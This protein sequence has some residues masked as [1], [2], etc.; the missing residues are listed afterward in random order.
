MIPKTRN[1]DLKVLMKLF[2][3][4]QIL[5]THINYILN[6]LQILQFMY[7]AEIFMNLLLGFFQSEL[8]EMN[9]LHKVLVVQA[10]LEFALQ[11]LLMV[12]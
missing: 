9:H 5:N 6:I 7:C 1:N 11:D 8:Q 4:K 12:L 3:F 10:T 2:I